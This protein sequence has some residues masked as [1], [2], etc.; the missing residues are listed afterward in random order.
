MSGV[1]PV[2]SNHIV[3]TM[4]SN[5]PICLQE[6]LETTASDFSNDYSLD[7]SDK[8]GSSKQKRFLRNRKCEYLST[9]LV[10]I[11]PALAI[12]GIGI[13]LYVDQVT[14]EESDLEQEFRSDALRYSKVVESEVLSAVNGLGMLSSFFE[15]SKSSK[16]ITLQ[17]FRNFTKRFLD[18]NTNVFEFAWAPLVT[19]EE[20]D[21]FTTLA[22]MTY[23]NSRLFVKEVKPPDQISVPS[24]GEVTF[25]NR[26]NF[27]P[28]SNRSWYFPVFLFDQN[29]NS[30]RSGTLMLDISKSP[31]A[32]PS[33][34]E[35]MATLEPVLQRPYH[36]VRLKETFTTFIQACVS[37]FGD[38]TT[39]IGLT[40]ATLH[41]ETMLINSFSNV[42][43][44]KAEGLNLY[45][46]LTT[47]QIVARIFTATNSS[48]DSSLIWQYSTNYTSCSENV[49]GVKVHG[50]FPCNL[51]TSNAALPAWVTRYFF[52][53]GK[54]TWCILVEENKTSLD[55]HW[56]TG[57][58]GLVVF[59]VLAACVLIGGVFVIKREKKLKD[60]HLLW[61]KEAIEKK[62]AIK[63]NKAKKQF[64]SYVFHE[65]RVP[66]NSLFIAIECMLLK[67]TDKQSERY[68][69]LK[70][71][72][73]CNEQIL[74]ILNEVLDMSKIEEG[75]LTLSMNYFV[76]S[77]FLLCCFSGLRATGDRK[78]IDALY[79]Y[80]TSPFEDVLEDKT[81]IWVLGDEAR[82]QQCVNNL[83]SNALKFT[84]P[85]GFVK[86]GAEVVTKRKQNYKG[87]SSP[88]V[89][90]CKIEEE[91]VII[92]DE[93]E[94]DTKDSTD[95]NG[96]RRVD[97]G[98]R[99]VKEE[100]ELVLEVYVQD[101]GVGISQEGM[102][103]LFHPYTQV[104][105][106]SDGIRPVE[107]GTGLGLCIVKSIIEKHGGEI[108][109]DSDEG[110]GTTFTIVLPLSYR[111]K[112]RECTHAQEPSEHKSSNGN[113]TS[114]STSNDKELEESPPALGKIARVL[115]V[116]DNSA[117]RTMM[118]ILLRGIGIGHIEFANNG[119]EAVQM[120]PNTS[121]KCL[122]NEDV[123]L[124]EEQERETFDV[125]L[126]D[127]Q[128]PIMNGPSCALA[129]RELGVQTPIIAC[130]G[131]VLKEE[132]AEFEASGVNSFLAKPIKRKDLVEELKKYVNL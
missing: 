43:P 129:L 101:S 61:T 25:P 92:S 15:A 67:E 3:Y 113:F 84:R 36:S 105:S 95:L 68:E 128:M 2:I 103:K 130:T 100:G 66:F 45:V 9:F 122:Q 112:K 80:S 86:F 44:P 69:S 1:F 54:E 8:T 10:P 102:A 26:V 91:V 49:N 60:L 55:A 110:K 82:L 90:E 132:R 11:L 121:Q 64:L 50:Y 7:G 65:V 35:A 107:K 21:N 109:V 24:I 70:I 53:A 63:T 99:D 83:I 22:R 94:V 75:K 87:N 81:C 18:S 77:D 51:C 71:A 111:L 79:E 118:S 5:N 12:A 88:W 14:D 85:G 57:V 37:V 31:L 131:S 58:I 33:A 52:S 62:Y 34:N 19:L 13:W 74:H 38:N 126:M 119:V 17:Q 106:N 93:K 120:F 23:N 46:V 4:V 116:E 76:L 41:L 125:I 20:K 39:I 30:K 117:T 29:R 123:G 40:T 127:N 47:T 48:E 42:F 114:S 96:A 6:S 78:G 115:V 108:K 97:Y 89:E 16:E 98:S 73:N 59:F 32:E 72:S 27:G 56:S 124:T 104:L 28:V